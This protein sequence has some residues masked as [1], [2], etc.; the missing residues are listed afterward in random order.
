MLVQKE[1]EPV[2]LVLS[3]GGAKGAAHVG[4]LLELEK[5]GWHFE[6]VTGASIGALVGAGYSLL[7]QAKP[8]LYYAHVMQRWVPGKVS[9]TGKNRRGLGK[10]GRNPE[11]KQRWMCVF[12]AVLPGIFPY[13]LYASGLRFFLRGK[14]FEDGAIPFCCTVVDWKQGKVLVFRSGKLLPA[15]LSS[16]AIPGVFRPQCVKTRRLVDGGTLDNLPVEVALQLG[17]KRVLAVHLN[18][19]QVDSPD[20][21]ELF[22]NPPELQHANQAFKRVSDIRF[23][24]LSRLSA[25]RADVVIDVD[26][27]GF[28]NLD[29]TRT[30]EL[31]ERGRQAVRE[32]R[33]VLENAL[34]GNWPSAGPPYQEPE[35]HNPV[36]LVAGGYGWECVDRLEEPVFSGVHKRFPSG[37]WLVNGFSAIPVARALNPGI[38]GFPSFLQKMRKL[39]NDRESDRFGPNVSRCRQDFSGL[40]VFDEQDFPGKDI[41]LKHPVRCEWVCVKDGKV[42]LS[43]ISNLHQLLLY[44]FCTPGYL[45]PIEGCYNSS[46]LVPFPGLSLEGQRGQTFVLLFPPWQAPVEPPGHPRTIARSLKRSQLLSSRFLCKKNWKLLAKQNRVLEFQLAPH[47]NSKEIEI[48]TPVACDPEEYVWL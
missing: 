2:A 5:M 6:L 36:Q 23:F 44:A 37:Q 3:G 47:G 17:A 24:H 19:H 8:L 34:G 33:E 9:A 39:W 43:E 38:P 28:R 4:V 10:K 22:D 27:R 29:F 40:A 11:R 30:D 1:G 35:Q 16:M 32:Q 41:P 25:Q 46:I 21:D 45:A 20:T 31:I 18:D 15:L 13:W 12:S 7:G 14:R 42:L 26:T 48:D